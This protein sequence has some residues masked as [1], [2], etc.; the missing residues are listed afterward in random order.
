MVWELGD[1]WFLSLRHLENRCACSVLTEVEDDKPSEWM[2][3]P[4][5]RMSLNAWV[6][7]RNKAAKSFLDHQ[8]EGLKLKSNI[9]ESL[10]W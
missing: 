6:T 1:I 9:Q 7:T 10:A 3:E 5:D 2:K 4:Q 8:S